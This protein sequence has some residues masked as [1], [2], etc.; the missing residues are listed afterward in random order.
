[1]D[2]LQVSFGAPDRYTLVAVI[3]HWVIAVGVLVQ[4]SMGWALRDVPRGVPLRT[5]VVN[6]HKS[7]GI[8]LGVLILIR[9]IWRLGHKVPPP[10]SGLPTW[11]RVSAKTSHMLLYVLMVVMPASGYIA[12]N[13]SKFGIK[14]FNSSFTL[15]PWGPDDKAVYAFFNTLHVT[16]AW[17]LMALITLHILAA[18]H[19]LI[20]RRDGVFQRM[21][22]R[23]R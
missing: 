17:V 6:N 10:P 11:Q 20:L 5:I 19:H 7:L 1:M 21:L 15:P 13:F 18:L 2:R 14:Y 16:S 8:T 4:I 9:L 12:T 22:P 23:W 3:L